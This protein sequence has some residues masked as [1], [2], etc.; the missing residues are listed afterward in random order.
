MLQLTAIPPFCNQCKYMSMFLMFVKLIG[1]GFT[2]DNFSLNYYPF[3][4]NDNE[5]KSSNKSA[6]RVRTWQ[7]MKQ[8]T[9][10][11]MSDTSQREWGREREL[12]SNIYT[13]L[14]LLLL[15]LLTQS[16]PVATP[17]T[18]PRANLILIIT[19]TKLNQL[20]FNHYFFRTN[21][22]CKCFCEYKILKI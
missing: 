5:F 12:P 22:Y 16:T 15:P 17:V 13:N 18:P 2:V 20:L 10:G 7:R 11:A 21:H 8:E 4:N 14:P 3:I 9:C 1:C 6:V 19:L